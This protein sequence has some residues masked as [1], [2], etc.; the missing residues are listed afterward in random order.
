MLESHATP[1]AE[2]M[3]KPLKDD[4]RGLTIVVATLNRGPSLKTTLEDLLAQ[5]Y[6]PLEILVVD[7]SEQTDH[8]IAEL[9]ARVPDRIQYHH[10]AFRSLPRARN[11]G[12]QRARFEKILFVDDDIRASSDLALEHDEAL[13]QP[14]VGVVAGGVDELSEDRSG[15]VGDYCYWLAAPR[16]A[17]GAVG[18]FDVTSAKGCN[19]STHRRVLERVGGID[20]LL[21]VGAALHEETEF[22][23]RVRR[24][25]FRVVFHGRARLLHLAAPSGGCRV[26]EPRRYVRALSHN[27]ALMIRR[28]LAPYHYPTALMRL[29]MLGASYARANADVGVVRELASGLVEG[30][31]DGRREPV[32][33][34]G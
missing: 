7:Q 11:Y 31:K 32:C 19:F 22:C 10:V 30:L 20:E 16:G 8:A 23:L 4:G 21:G 15:R 24:A 33:T 5:S 25:G 1:K 34:L 14:G 17:F 9:V 12:W 6:E 26:K 13:S 3:S 18:S 27:R 28:H 2:T 29:L